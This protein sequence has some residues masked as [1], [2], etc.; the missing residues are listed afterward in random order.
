MIGISPLASVAG[1]IF[2]V[3]DMIDGDH[4]VEESFWNFLTSMV[5]L[6]NEVRIIKWEADTVHPQYVPYLMNG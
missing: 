1:S 2:A 5:D 4:N 6:P 3:C